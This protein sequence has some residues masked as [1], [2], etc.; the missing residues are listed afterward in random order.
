MAAGAVHYFLM[1]SFLLFIAIA[2]FWLATAMKFGSVMKANTHT[3]GLAIV[4]AGNSAT[5]TC[6]AGRV[7][8]PFRAQYLCGKQSLGAGDPCD[9]FL[10]NGNYDSA[11][12]SSALDDLNGACRD[13]TGSCTFTLGDTAVLPPACGA[14][15][16]PGELMLNASY[17]CVPA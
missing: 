9:P 10:P 3:R 11:A 6:P 14:E 5:L 2:I 15:C 17:D 13:Q 12:T 8:R 16:S 1:M 4:G 7:I